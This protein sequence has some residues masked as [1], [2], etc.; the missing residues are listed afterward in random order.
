M[1]CPACDKPIRKNSSA[2]RNTIFHVIPDVGVIGTVSCPHCSVSFSVKQVI[3]YEP[4]V[5]PARR[6]SDKRPNIMQDIKLNHYH[7]V[8]LPGKLA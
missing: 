6:A 5:T 1:M 3:A 2:I 8:R 4:T 7:L